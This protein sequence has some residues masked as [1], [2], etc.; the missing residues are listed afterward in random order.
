[1]AESLTEQ[2]ESSRELSDVNRETQLAPA[3][4][5]AQTINLNSA[6]AEM[7]EVWLVDESN[8]LTVQASKDSGTWNT[9]EVE[10]RGSID[11][12]NWTVIKTLTAVGMYKGLNVEDY[13]FVQ[14][15]DTVLE[16]GAG[17]ARFKGYGK[18]VLSPFEVTDKKTGSFTADKTGLCIRCDPT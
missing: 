3:T 7:A 17:V 14:I 12:S 18:A 11:N 15:V 2:K 5:G 4:L 10:V 6:S 1:M 16:G 9:A 8:R 13:I